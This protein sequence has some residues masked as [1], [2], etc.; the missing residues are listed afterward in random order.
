MCT[1]VLTRGGSL[2]ENR[3]RHDQRKNG[4]IL[5]LNFDFWTPAVFDLEKTSAVSDP[6][7]AELWAAD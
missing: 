5:Q 7:G 2:S 4:E 3:H 1:A 6:R